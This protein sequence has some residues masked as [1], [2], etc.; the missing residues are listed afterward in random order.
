MKLYTRF[1]N[2]SRYQD[3]DCDVVL[4]KAIMDYSSLRSQ[5]SALQSSLNGASVVNPSIRK[6]IQ[7]VRQNV[8]AAVFGEDG[9]DGVG[10]SPFSQESEGSCDFTLSPSSPGGTESNSLSHSITPPKRVGQVTVTPQSV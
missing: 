2:F 4:K 3:C 1:G 7:Q 10:R 8:S 6:K 9:G 5:I